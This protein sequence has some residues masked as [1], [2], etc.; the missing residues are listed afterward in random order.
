MKEALLVNDLNI[1]LIKRMSASCVT[2]IAENK[3]YTRQRLC[4][5]LAAVLLAAA[6]ALVILR[7]YTVIVL[8]LL[9][10]GALNVACLAAGVLY[11]AFTALYQTRFK[12]WLATSEKEE[13]ESSL[14]YSA[15]DVRTMI[16]NSSNCRRPAFGLAMF[17]ALTVMAGVLTIMLK[18][19]ALDTLLRISW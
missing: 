9:A 12:T 10:A 13:R 2:S 7:R 4:L 1:E 16:T 15:R 19:G 3:N 14:K 11:L 6:V 8:I 5:A 17:L 18:E